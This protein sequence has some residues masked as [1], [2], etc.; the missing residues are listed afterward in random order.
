MNKLLIFLLC[1]FAAA[2]AW[3][4]DFLNGDVCEVKP[5]L[6]PGFVYE[7]MCK[8]YE[9]ALRPGER[10]VIVHSLHSRQGGGGGRDYEWREDVLEAAGK[11][12]RMQ[13][14]GKKVKVLEVRGDI[15]RVQIGRKSK[16]YMLA[17][18]L[19]KKD[20]SQADSA[21]VWQMGDEVFTPTAVVMFKLPIPVEKHESMM[22]ED[23]ARAE[24][25][26]WMMH[27]TRE[28]TLSEEGEIMTVLQ[29]L[30]QVVEVKTRRGKWWVAAK[31]L[32]RRE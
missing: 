1:V 5:M 27:E 18:D 6:A 22:K 3:G 20:A 24:K 7:K 19:Q 21:A 12:V 2:A 29:Q 25:Y 11:D 15:V 8:R 23:P 4:A 31:H 10:P 28:V 32:Q 17:E 14:K 16:L 30:R 13:K 9:R 26:L